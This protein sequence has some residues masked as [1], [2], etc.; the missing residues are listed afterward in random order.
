MDM[1]DIR[2]R[3][4]T[5]VRTM[6]LTIP[7]DIDRVCATLG[8]QRGRVFVLEPTLHL[9]V[10]TTGRW[11]ATATADII[12]YDA[13]L[14]GRHRLQVIFHEIGHSVCG[15]EPTAEESELALLR[16]LDKL[17]PAAI[18]HINGRY[19]GRHPEHPDEIEAEG[20]S[21]LVL[22]E[23]DRRSGSVAYGED[24]PGLRGYSSFLFFGA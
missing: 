16:T 4:G 5:W 17:T 6:P 8:A 22:E 15:H 20:F 18:R 24:D 23:I 3:W 21:A 11:L 19:R 9:P 2:R 1:E 12:Q 14:T 7:V 10:G 13:R